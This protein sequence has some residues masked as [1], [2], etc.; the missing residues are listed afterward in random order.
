MTEN[1]TE[2]SRPLVVGRKQDGRNCYDPEA[3]RDLVEV[4]LQPGISVARLAMQH[5]VNANLL[6]TWIGRYRKK[7]ESAGAI[8]A[9]PSAFIP[10]VGAKVAA[11]QGGGG[12][13]ATL[14][15]GVRLDL[16]GLT[17]HELPQL[18]T[19]LSRLP[20]SGSPQG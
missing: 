5:G 12:L 20:C 1:T 10:V 19:W 7:H 16:S 17:E 2:L 11:P 18:L 6:R 15:N 9:Q 3:K 13:W 14:P 4:C 8:L